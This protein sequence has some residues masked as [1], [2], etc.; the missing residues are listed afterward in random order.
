ML[1][2]VNKF[3]CWWFYQVM[4]G[5]SCLLI[6]FNACASPYKNSS[7]SGEDWAYY[8]GTP[9]NN[10]YSSLHQIN[11]KNVNN[12]QEAWRFETHE[13]GDP[14]TNPLIIDGTLYGFTPSLNLVALNA[15]TGALRWKF[16]AGLSGTTLSSGKIFT[17]PARGLMY[18][19]QGK[20]QRLFAGVMNFLYAI[21]PATGLP[22]KSFGEQGAID[23]RKDLGGDFNQHYVSLTTP[24]VI[25]K[26]L[27]IVGFRTAEN[28][29]AP[30]GDIRAYDVRT[31]K[32]RWSFHTIPH[33]GELGANT[34][35]QNPTATSGAANSWAGMSLDQKRGI[36][37][38]PTGSAVPDFYGSERLGDNLFSNCLI[39]IDAT[40]GKRLWHFQTTHHDIWDRDLPSPPVL[41][42]LKNNGKSIDVVAQPS[43]QGFLFVFD[44]VTGKPLFPIEEL[45]APQSE[46]P[47][48]VSA[49]TQPFPTVPAPFARQQ[50]TED[51][52][53]TRTPEAH[54]WA[55]E[56]FR[57]LRSQGQ[58][59]PFSLGKQTVLFPGF[60]GGAE[61]GG[62]A[63]D[64]KSGIIYINA[65][66]I[67]WTGGLTENVN[68]NDTGIQIFNAQCSVC[69]GA[70]RKGSP[71]AFPSL[72]DITQRLSAEDIKR[73]VKNGRGR[74]PPFASLSDEQLQHVISALG[75]HNIDKNK[76]NPTEIST[77]AATTKRE[78]VSPFTD[79][80]PSKY[81]F[82][83]YNKFLDP[84]GYPA[85]V[86][87][88]G[89]LNAI[90]LHTGKY[91]WKVPLG[92]YP[93]LVAK[94]MSNTGSENYGGPLLTASGL[95]FI[96]A[97]I[98]DHK[99]RA[100]DSNTGNLIWQ[101]ELPFAGTA[102]P[103]TYMVNGKQ[104]LVIE[105]NNARNP[106]GPQGNAYVAFSLP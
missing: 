14:Q 24:G 46:I 82:T 96:A 63:V 9:L 77:T 100:F 80:M 74:M 44:R 45:A 88:W 55:L 66:D 70:D 95:I 20:E 105:T 62:S 48:E 83:G 1:A 51:M 39:A 49:K 75:E 17:G 87:P 81:R 10:R 35:P 18:W 89:T 93:E 85:V 38:V 92:E 42:T 73:V 101:A 103:A 37:Y 12:L 56:K 33:A 31:G 50:L 2:S 59:M 69:H 53:T 60:D 54:A 98:Y 71:P 34:W 86:P 16:D 5:L 21:N 25:Y 58:F 43:K 84:D 91:L 94:G 97:T 78:M 27:L 68:T 47:G 13:T 7:A 40:T 64:P 99:I 102:T 26:D 28:P 106:K 11:K 22:I 23:L 90:D 29:P 8:G 67:P 32:L 19:A 79:N 4:A 61:W 52:L 36:V 15:V 57:S 3:Q 104:Y 76:S 72:V 30:P 41:V 6:T 65:N